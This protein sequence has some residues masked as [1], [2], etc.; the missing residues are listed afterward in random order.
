MLIVDALFRVGFLFEAN[1]VVFLILGAR[2][3]FWKFL[4]WVELLYDLILDLLPF[5]LS[6]DSSKYYSESPIGS[7]LAV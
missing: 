1:V 3:L 7:T 2:S 4:L 6:K 5:K